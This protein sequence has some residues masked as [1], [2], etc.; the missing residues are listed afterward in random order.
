M[1]LAVD[2]WSL[3]LLLELGCESR[4]DDVTTVEVGGGR[5]GS[6]GGDLGAEDGV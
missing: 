3:L 4:S 6:D 2:D 1:G 5:D